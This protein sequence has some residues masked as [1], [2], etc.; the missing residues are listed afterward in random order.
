LLSRQI[1]HSL[2]AVAAVTAAV[3]VVSMVVAEAASM[4]VASTVV[5]DLMAAPDPLVE[6]VATRVA[7][8]VVDQRR[9]VMEW[10]A[11]PTVGSVHREA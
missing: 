9:V 1:Q 8:F 10:R 4:A 6:E 3:A 7:A 5:A 11:A 2:S